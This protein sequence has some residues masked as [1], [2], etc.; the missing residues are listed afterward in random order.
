MHYASLK[1][2]ILYRPNAAYAEIHGG[3]I[4][5][6]SDKAVA[7]N[8]TGEMTLLPQQNDCWYSLGRI[9]VVVMS[10]VTATSVIVV[11]TIY[12]VLTL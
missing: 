9:S 1:K 2:T 4:E 10:L 12:V 11:V 5:A 8:I 3:N 7:S 6:K